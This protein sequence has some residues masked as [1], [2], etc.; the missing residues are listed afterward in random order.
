MELIDLRKEICQVAYDAKGCDE[1]EQRCE[2]NRLM[3]NISQSAHYM[4]VWLVAGNAMEQSLHELSV[5]HNCFEDTRPEIAKWDLFIATKIML[6]LK[7]ER[8]IGK[9]DNELRVMVVEVLMFII[10]VTLTMM[11]SLATN[12]HPEDAILM[13]SGE[14]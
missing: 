5:H 14:V 6:V 1:D 13:T 11:A 8:N 3:S 12:I 2:I 9:S 10:N 7:D 4:L